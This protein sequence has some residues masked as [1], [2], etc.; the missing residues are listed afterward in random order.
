MLV[1]PKLPDTDDSN[2]LVVISRFDTQAS[3]LL[4]P[5]RPDTDNAVGLRL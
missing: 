3:N 2:L 5:K 1:V 4:V